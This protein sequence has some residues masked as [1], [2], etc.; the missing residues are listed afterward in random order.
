[1]R[2]S[3]ATP[4]AIVLRLAQR[5]APLLVLLLALLGAAC[6]PAVTPPA[7]AVTPSPASAASP[8]P[9]P[10]ASP[11]F[12]LTITDDAGRTVTLGATPTRIVSIAPSNTEILFAVGA[13]DR[14]VAV[15]RFSDY[16]P[17]A[18]TRESLG[19]Y[20]KPDLEK[21]VAAAPDLVLATNVHTK[22]LVPQLESRGITVIV[23]EPTD[24]DGV[25]ER[26][27][28]VGR[29]T[30]NE[31]RA[32]ELV[33]ELRR[34][35]EAVNAKVA[36]A[37]SPRIFFEIDPKLY[38]AGPGTFIHDLIHRAGGTNIAADATTQYPQLSSETVV[39]KDP[40]VIVLADD[41]AGQSPETVKARPGW[42][43]V[44]AVRT[45]RIVSIHPDLTNRPG[46]RLV[47]GLEALAKA[48]HPD[49]FR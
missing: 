13:G 41:V 37:P 31:L 43:E 1:M 35:I 23:I 42:R 17:E 9:T 2:R 18:K 46:P 32:A 48:L 21:L 40:E 6:A 11:A 29:A 10:T 27:L 8:S 14:V 16:P 30:G 12:P 24:L 5:P 19:S 26:I 20:V 15:D 34:R 49:R 28:L 45:G 22:Q 25:L 7:P 4:L 38:T 44:S 33:R 3:P 47:D 39:L 36:G